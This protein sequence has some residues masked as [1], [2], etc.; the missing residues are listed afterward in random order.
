MKKLTG[1]LLILGIMFGFSAFADN[2]ITVVLE[3]E[4]LVF[5][6]EPVIVNDRTMVPMRK[7]FEELG[8]TVSWDGEESRVEAAFDDGTYIILYINGNMAYKNESA[9]KLDSPA[10]IK[11]GRTMVPLRFVSEASGANVKWDGETSTVNI[12]PKWRNI[13]FIPFSDNMDVPSPATADRKM[14]I[15]DGKKDGEASVYTYDIS[16]VDAD[17]VAKY[18]QILVK[19]R[20][21]C[22]SGTVTDGVKI[23]WNGSKAVKTTL[24]GTTYTIRVYRASSIDDAK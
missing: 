2:K 1:F 9:I 18:E 24:E 14:K 21:T 11:D 17:T 23:F 12:T 16:G 15:T 22:I 4:E 20:F 6:T 10:Y 8:A 3:D 19:L 5:D 7:I 13:D